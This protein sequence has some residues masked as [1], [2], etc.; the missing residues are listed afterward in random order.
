MSLCLSEPLT[1]LYTPMVL[2]GY[3]IHMNC[4]IFATKILDSLSCIQL[5]IHKI[6]YMHRYIYIRIYIDIYLYTSNI[7]KAIEESFSTGSDSSN[8]TI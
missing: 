7:L 2:H 3:S 1:H 4:L 5:Q 8:F 6:I